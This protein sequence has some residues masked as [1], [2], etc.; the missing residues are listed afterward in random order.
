[1]EC[2]VKFSISTRALDLEFPSAPTSSAPGSCIPIANHSPHAC[3]PVRSQ[4]HLALKSNPGQAQDV[5]E[6]NLVSR[7]IWYWTRGYGAALAISHSCHHLSGNNK[8]L[9]R[10]SLQSQIRGKHWL[11]PVMN[12][13]LFFYG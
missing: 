12:D 11:E 4:A 6:T 2:C 3:F 9:W 13:S 1:M 10:S 5:S 7:L 8:H